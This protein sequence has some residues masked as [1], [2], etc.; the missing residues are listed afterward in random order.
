[1]VPDFMLRR[2]FHY[3]VGITCLTVLLVYVC[4]PEF[5]TTEKDYIEEGQVK[6]DGGKLDFI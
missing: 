2:S 3:F 5:R 1:M 6:N 4:Q